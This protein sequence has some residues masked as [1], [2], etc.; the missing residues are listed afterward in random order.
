MQKESLDRCITKKFYIQI[1]KY[2]LTATII[3]KLNGVIS[4]SRIHIS[5][6]RHICLSSIFSSA[7]H[8][9]TIVKLSQIYFSHACRQIN[10]QIIPD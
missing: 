5:I 10:R 6:S 9:T 3:C 7:Y 4:Y 2:M 8:L 1:Y